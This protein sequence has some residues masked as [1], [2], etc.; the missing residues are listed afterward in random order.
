[1]ACSIYRGFALIE[2]L[3]VIGIMTVIGLSVFVGVQSYER[4][5]LF[6]EKNL[7]F[8]LL[9]EARGRSFLGYPAGLRATPIEYIYFFGDSYDSA[10]RTESYKRESAI[11]NNIVDDII[12]DNGEN[13]GRE[14]IFSLGEEKSLR[15]SINIQKNG[16]MF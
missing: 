8:A 16:R 5:L 13:S 14:I 2:I 3:I 6:R 10:L 12:F 4:S 1:M 9:S 15:A 11:K 7:V